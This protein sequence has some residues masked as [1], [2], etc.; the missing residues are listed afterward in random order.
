M[1]F[2][3]LCSLKLKQDNEQSKEH[4][5]RNRFNKKRDT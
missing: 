2:N 3:Y 5:K 1:F 4:S